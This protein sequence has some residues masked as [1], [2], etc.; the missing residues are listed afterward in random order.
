MARVFYLSVALLVAGLL[1]AL[2]CGST[3][4]SSP[5]APVTG[6]VV[7]SDSLVAGFGCGTKP[8]QI[9]RYAAVVIDQNGQAVAGATYDCFSDGSFVNLLGTDGGAD[10]G[11]LD[12]TVQVFAFNKDAYAQSSAQIEAAVASPEQLALLNPT[13]TTACR[14]TQQTN[15]EVL[16]V[17]GP[18]TPGQGARVR[19]DTATFPRQSGGNA[20]CDRV[21]GDGGDYLQVVGSFTVNDAPAD[22]GADLSV[23]CPA[24]LRITHA[25]APAAYTLQLRLLSRYG[26]G[27]GG[28]VIGKTTCRAQTKPGLEVVA[29]CDPVN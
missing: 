8:E 29:A 16:A 9:F 10:G 15:I 1:A 25:D 22:A 7:R 14:A 12:F 2:A 11:Q 17:C 19:V 4:V 27:D 3:P 21:G 20:L 5:L 24:P 18:L 23:S 28:S 26:R 13:W 6:I